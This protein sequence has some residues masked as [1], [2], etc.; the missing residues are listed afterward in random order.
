MVFSSFEFLIYFLPGFLLLYYLMPGKLKNLCLFAGSLVFYSYGVKGHPLY[1]LLIAGSVFVNYEVGKKIGKTRRKR[2]RRHWLTAGLIYNIGWLVF[3]KYLDFLLENINQLGAL[4][5]VKGGIPYLHLA[6]PIGISF[7][8]FQIS[9]YLIDVYRKDTKAESSFIALGTYLC[10]FPQLI[11]GPIVTYQSVSLQ[12]KERRHSLARIEEG[13]KLFTIGLGYK[14]LIANRVSGLW[15][16][17]KG[18][19]F[20]SISTPL[21]WLGLLAFSFQIYFDFYG[22]S[23]M[24]KGLGLLLGFR[25]PDN[26]NCPYMALSMTDFW[27]RWHITLGNWFR[28]Y[29]YIPLGGNRRGTVICIRNMLIVWLLTGLWHGASWNFILWGLCIFLLMCVEKAGWGRV[30]ERFPWLGHLYMALVIPLTWLLFAVKDLGEIKLYFTRLFPFLSNHAGVV[31]KGDYLKYGSMY[32][33]SMT[34]AL[35]LCTG[36]QTKWYRKWK[37]KWFTAGVLTAVFWGAIY[38]IHMGM[39]DPFLYFNF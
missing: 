23:L 21:A 19:G 39:N 3:F 12:L 32:G 34:A 25:F 22:Y 10:M 16:Q 26:F 4:G 29:V 7:Y 20:D 5:G 35:I 13:L 17:V 1:L 37:Y 33:I 8:T 11:A 24:A 2:V 27:R 38:C 28:E 31:F 18:I 6:L 30:T 15:N 36:I 14:V 9:S